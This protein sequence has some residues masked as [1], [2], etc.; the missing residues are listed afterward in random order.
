MSRFYTGSI[1]DNDETTIYLTSDSTAAGKGAKL[2][3]AGDDGFADDDAVAV[4]F[5]ADNTPHYQAAPL[6]KKGIQFA[7]KILVCPVALKDSL[8]ALI[9]PT[10]STSAT[11]RVRL[12]SPKRNIDV[13]AKAASDWTSTGKW[14]GEMIQD[15][16]FRFIS[17]GS[18]S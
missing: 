17:M 13:Q 15:V 5:G 2:E 16:V 11:V 18:G 10:R 3:V 6:N 4:T 8:E 7:V 14:S 12:N 9:K 1:S